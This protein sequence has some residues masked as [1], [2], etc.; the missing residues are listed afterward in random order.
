MLNDLKRKFEIDSIKAAQDFDKIVSV[1][2]PSIANEKMLYI[3]TIDFVDISHK[4]INYIAK[5][6]IDTIILNKQLEKSY[7]SLMY[8]MVGI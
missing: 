7:N 4:L 8:P 3:S 1:D 2:L 6:D 5:F